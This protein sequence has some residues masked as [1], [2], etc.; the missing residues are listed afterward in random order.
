MPSPSP[1]HTS[2]DPIHTQKALATIKA[3]LQAGNCPEYTKNAWLYLKKG[4]LELSNTSV[5]L[6][7]DEILK[8]LSAMKKKLSG[9]VVISYI[10]YKSSHSIIRAI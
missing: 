9:K 3:F 6:A 5:T 7:H 2:P 1:E 4:L 8:R 10:C